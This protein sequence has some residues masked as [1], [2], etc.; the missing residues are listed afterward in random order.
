MRQYH[1][2]VATDPSSSIFF[3]LL[4]RTVYFL[5]HLLLNPAIVRQLDL[6]RD[7]VV[8]TVGWLLLSSILFIGWLVSTFFTWRKQRRELTQRKSRL[9]SNGMPHSSGA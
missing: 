8:P 2:M 4:A 1:E 5:L 6:T 3:L 9:E 7:V